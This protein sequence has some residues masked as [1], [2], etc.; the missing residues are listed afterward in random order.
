M[1]AEEEGLLLREFLQHSLN[2]SRTAIK[3]IKFAGGELC[4]DGR[5]V[6]VRQVLK[7]KDEV[8]VVFPP[9]EN[10]DGIV[11]TETPLDLLFEDE[12]MLVL[13]KPAGVP[14]VPS[15]QNREETLANGVLYYL[16]QKNY[17][18]TAHPVTRLDSE[19]SGLVLFAKHSVAHDWFSRMQ[20]SGAIHREYLAMVEGS[21]LVDQGTIAEPIGRKLG[22]IIERCVTPEGKH[23]VT[24]FTKIADFEDYSIV[25]IKLETGRTHQI[26]VHFAHIGH[27][28][29]GDDL[30]GGS[31]Q[32]IQR[33]ALH[34]HKLYFNHP[35]TNQAMAFTA[36]LPDEMQKILDRN[37][38]QID[39]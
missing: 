33:Q 39:F 10:G 34:S 16:Q 20:K 13:N 9:E 25:G 14:T 23:A 7:E 37:S 24:H 27:P 17:A 19:T 11:A 35:V 26:R 30:Y 6:T 3:K 21:L 36:P 31:T 4:V 1:S 2:L 22:S 28:L 32:H 5:P 8:K 15:P 12:S 29:L 18:Y 38:F